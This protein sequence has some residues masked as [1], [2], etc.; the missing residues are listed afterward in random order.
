M[1]SVAAE[2]KGFGRFSPTNPNY[3]LGMCMRLWQGPNLEVVSGRRLVHELFLEELCSLLR[4]WNVLTSA[5][6]DYRGKIWL[7]RCCSQFCGSQSPLPPKD[8]CFSLSL[9]LDRHLCV[10]QTVGTHQKMPMCLLSGS[11]CNCT[12]FR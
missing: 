3:N 12:E 1:P 5:L 7:C 2:C 9:S 11:H 8:Y 4:V 6:E 10:A